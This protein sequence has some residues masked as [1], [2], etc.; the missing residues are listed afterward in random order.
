[1][2]LQTFPLRLKAKETGY[3]WSAM[4]KA[5]IGLCLLEDKAL[6]LY[7]DI[8]R[9]R[10][11][12]LA[13]E[14]FPLLASK[15]HTTSL[16]HKKIPG[17]CDTVYEGWIQEINRTYVGPQLIGTWQQLETLAAQERISHLAETRQVT[18]W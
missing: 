11:I 12:H 4:N 5:G 8:G 9:H 1:M 10:T 14:V 3:I 16:S 7:T 6:M 15:Q 2:F 18:T 17:T 13:S